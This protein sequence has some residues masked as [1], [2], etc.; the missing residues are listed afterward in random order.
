LW[1]NMGKSNKSKAMAKMETAV[2]PVVDN[3]RW[4]C[5]VDLEKKLVD[6]KTTVIATVNPYAPYTIGE[7]QPLKQEFT[8]MDA[9]KTHLSGEIDKAFGKIMGKKDADKA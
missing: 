1:R 7:K 4:S 2:I 3:N 8:D 9:L 6:G 5:G